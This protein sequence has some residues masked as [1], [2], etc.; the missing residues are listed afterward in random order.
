MRSERWLGASAM[1]AAGLLACQAVTDHGTPVNVRLQPADTTVVLGEV[2]TVERLVSRD[3]GDFRPSSE[4]RWT[5]VDPAP[6]GPAAASVFAGWFDAA[7]VLGAVGVG[8]ARFENRVGTAVD[9]FTITVLAPR[10]SLVPPLYAGRTTTCAFDEAGDPWCWGATRMLG[11]RRAASGPVAEWTEPRFSQL[12]PRAT[13]FC[14]LDAN[15]AAWCWMTDP[16]LRGDGMAGNPDYSSPRQPLG[17][18]RF[19]AIDGNASLRCGLKVAGELWCWGDDAA[20]ATGNPE[21]TEMCV[22]LGVSHACATVPT[23]AA[24]GRPFSTFAVGGTSFLC[25]AELG[26]GIVWCSGDNRFGQLGGP[27]EGQCEDS[28]GFSYPCSRVQLAVDSVVN[29]TA[30][31]AGRFFACALDETGAAWCWGHNGYGELGD[32]TG[33]DRVGPVRVAGGLTFTQLVAG[34]DHACALDAGGQA[35]C[36]GSAGMGETGTLGVPCQHGSVAITCEPAP[37]M[38]AGG[39]T[40]VSLAAGTWHT[41]GIRADGAVY[42]WGRNGSSMLGAETLN[43]A[44]SREPLLVVGTAAP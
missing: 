43:L 40:F 13:S 6:P 39:H 18:H 22:T 16:P 21:P 12:S 7:V 27:S 20:G 3:G 4:G 29:A 32:G 33:A 11:Q 28:N 30:L 9:T 35:Y 31:A 14:A 44:F 25:G 15:G 5:R 37:A 2:V 19:V 17:D 26:S 1:L 41:C 34:G 24:Q 38:V 36:W 10:V 42:C 23:L 8:T